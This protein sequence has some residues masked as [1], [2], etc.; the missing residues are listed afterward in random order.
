MRNH[1][2]ERLHNKR[3]TA[4][5]VA[6]AVCLVA[7]MVAQ[8]ALAIRQE[9]LT[10]DEDDHIFAGYMSWKHGDF[11][12]NPEHPPLVKLLAT[13]P[14]LNMPLHVPALQHRFFKTE[15]FLDG[16][17]FLA[18]NDADT[19][20]FRARMM[21]ALITVLM[22]VLVFLAG[23]EMFGVA[24]GFIA[25]ALVAF[26]PNLVA[27]GAFVTTDMALSCFLFAS[28]YAF[29]RY[30]KAPSWW[31][32]ALT[33]LAAGCALGAKHTGIFV[34]PILL[35]LAVCE[36]LRERRWKTA[37][38]LA[39][40][41]AG[42]SLIA[43]IVLWSFY[44]FRYS[45]RPAGMAVNPPLA[46][47]AGGMR[48]FDAWFI[49]TCAR[50]HLL[51]ES[52]LYGLVDVRKMVDWYPSFIF[53]KVY[54]HGVWFYFPAAFAI[55]STIPLLVLLV[56]AVVAV[57]MRRF[58]CWREILFLGIPAAIHFAVATFSTIN[59]GLRHILPVYVFLAVLLAGVAWNYIRRD[60]RW[61]WLVTALLVFQAITCLYN[62]PAYIA[63][64]NELWGGSSNTY[65]Y[66]SDSNADWAQ[67]LKA[68]KQYLDSRGVTGCW[69]AY[70]A[71]GVVDTGYY[72]I[73]CKPLVTA[74]TLWVNELTDI[75]PVIDGPVLISAG[76]LS[77]FEFGSDA[78]NPYRQ[79][80]QIRPAAMIQN[81]VL[82]FD[83][84]FHVARASALS[85]AQ[86]SWNLMHSG[87]FEEALS[88]TRMAVAADPTS[89]EAQQSLGDSLSALHRLDEARTAWGNAL[90][91][92]QRLE[93]GV[94]EDRIR[95]L[96]R[97]LAIR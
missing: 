10:W 3:R 96:Q 67:Q 60:L 71:E 82:V 61:A 50:W 57:A 64:A 79:F 41:L 55:K 56:M 78:L 70:F 39:G 62:F 65:K 37:P 9:S 54:P 93:P 21:A 97:R 73:P 92:A 72:G 75:P 51:P 66:L 63:Y 42:I 20:L 74:D 15:A 16:K 6:S 46:L 23:R 53:G 14:I 18:K 8:M 43:S 31:R 25:L 40:A 81:G 87:R 95:D 86:K 48:P 69:F 68:T 49:S 22:A 88:E 89:I 33:G 52:Y 77:G 84:R 1:V 59:I 13:L 91:L 32:L 58:R 36:A 80:Q 85:H 2:T 45:A 83:G 44:G 90:A 38:R 76:T 34:F 26:D 17:E 35:V 7:A 28:V 19:M 12:L 30:L 4:L 94:R 47:F 5:M 29:Y 27:H 11:G 24:A